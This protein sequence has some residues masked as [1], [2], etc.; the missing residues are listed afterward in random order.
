[1]SALVQSFKSRL[2]PLVDSL[3]QALTI[4]AKKWL[5]YG[6]C[7]YDDQFDIDLFTDGKPIIKTLKIE[8]LTGEFSIEFNAQSLKT[9]TRELKRE[10]L[11][12]LLNAILPFSQMLKENNATKFRADEFLKDIFDTYELG[13][14][15]YF[16]S[17]TAEFIKDEVRTEQAKIKITKKMQEG[18]LTDEQI[19]PKT[20]SEIFEGNA[21]REQIANQK[22]EEKEGTEDLDATP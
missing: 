15:K 5:L 6:I 14:Q 8:D 11:L 12:N 9:A 22:A 18:V 3:N 10:S 21:Q 16:T 7:Y 4:I 20:P 1:M 13:T 2:L 19:S 17:G